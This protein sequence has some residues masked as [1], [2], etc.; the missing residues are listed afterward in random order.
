M[1]PSIASLVDDIQMVRDIWTKLKMIYAGTENHMRV[2]QIQRDIDEVVQGDKSIQ[3][4]VIYLERMWANLNHFSPMSTCS[5]PKCKK[6][7]IFAQGRTM[8][9]LGGLSPTFDQRRSILLA[10]PT[11]PSLDE[12]IAAMI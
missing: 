9:F 10:Q 2:F 12:S 1:V 8:K 3:E 4:Y 6:G 11:I 7:K 5:D